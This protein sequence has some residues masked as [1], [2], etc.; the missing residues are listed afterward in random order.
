[1]HRTHVS[2]DPSASH[3]SY[4]F[5]FLLPVLLEQYPVA[6]VPPSSSQCRLFPKCMMYLLRKQKGEGTFETHLIGWCTRSLRKSS[7]SPNRVRIGLSPIFC[8]RNP[9]LQ[10]LQSVPSLPNRTHVSPDPSASHFSYG[11]LLHSLPVLS[12]QYPASVFECGVPFEHVELLI[13]HLSL[14]SRWY[15][16][17]HMRHC[18]VPSSLRN[19]QLPD[20]KSSN[21]YN[22]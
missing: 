8:S 6:H 14:E 15:P 2:P 3:S 10:D 11:V 17:A 7:P 18:S 21:P 12:L 4:G 22:G 9:G 20:V 16:G 1:M 13:L 19:C 5:P